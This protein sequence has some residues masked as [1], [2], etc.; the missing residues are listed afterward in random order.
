MR[1]FFFF[2][3]TCVCMCVYS[4]LCP[5]LCNPNHTD[6]SPPGSSVNEIF[7]A[8]ILEWVAIP[9][10]RGSSRPRD[11]TLV[12]CIS[13]SGR[14][15]PSPTSEDTPEF[16][17][18]R[19]LRVGLGDNF[20]VQ[21][22]VRKTNHEITGMEFRPPR[23]TSGNG[24][25]TG[26]WVQSLVSGWIKD[27]INHVH[28][29]KPWLQKKNNNSNKWSKEAGRASWLVNTPGFQEEKA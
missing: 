14:W 7:Q 19:R 21:T 2:N 16:M 13:C 10:S 3:H 11:R 12:S 20:S 18:T 23:L 28:M 17:L 15:I 26:D 1:P 4:Q 24:R 25:G 9:F 5:T 22:R 6:C 8:R 27:W 29:M